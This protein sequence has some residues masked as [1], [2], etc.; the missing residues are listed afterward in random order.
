MNRDSPWGAAREADP[1]SPA[2]AEPSGR[3]DAGQGSPSNRGRPDGTPEQGTGGLGGGDGPGVPWAQTPD[4]MAESSASGRERVPELG[5]EAEE[6]LDLAGVS[7]AT[8]APSLGPISADDSSGDSSE[9][10]VGDDGLA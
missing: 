10:E 6:D 8:P 7:V 1:S 5:R 4:A 3:G 9:E 2:A